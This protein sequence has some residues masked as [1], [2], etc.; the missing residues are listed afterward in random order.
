MSRIVSAAG[1]LAAALSLQPLAAQ[2]QAQSGKG[3]FVPQAAAP[4]SDAPHSVVRRPA[5]APRPRRG[6]GPEPEKN[7]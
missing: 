6:P 7:C 2:A 4:Q 5:P 1:V 3:W